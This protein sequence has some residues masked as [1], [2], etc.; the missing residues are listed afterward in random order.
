MV[1]AGIYPVV[2]SEYEVLR[3]ALEKLQI[4]DA[5]LVWSPETSLALGFGFRC[6]FL[7]ML[8]MEIV[9]ERLAREGNIDIVMTTPSVELHIFDKQGKM[10]CVHTPADMP[11]PEVI[12]R[13][14]EPI[15]Q[16]KI[17]TK[18]AFVGKVIE[19][20]MNKRGEFKNQIHLSADRAELIF[21]LPL[22]EI[23]FDFFDKLK[24][25]SRGYASLEYS[26]IGFAPA[27]LIKLDILIHGEPVDAL[28]SIVHRD[29]AH[30]LGKQVCEK[31]KEMIPRHLFEVPVQAAIGGKVVARSTIKAFRK[32][33]T[34]KL[35]GG[36]VERRK[37]LLEAQKRGKKRM[38]AIGKVNIPSDVFLKLLKVD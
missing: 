1:F 5:S 10:H 29:N 3:R 20:C 13:I 24:S 8:H 35:Y 9:K 17:I 21:N 18:T 6:G 25:I 38:K 27:K 32:D 11:V 4:N 28:S 12:D 23:V 7:G 19:L 34:A 31:A 22:S 36:H 33:V 2:N 14:E 37:K 26:P 15:V 30:R 16:V